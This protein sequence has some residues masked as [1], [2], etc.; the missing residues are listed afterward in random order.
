MKN[1]EKKVKIELFTE[2]TFISAGTFAE[3]YA[4]SREEISG[5]PNEKL[6]I[7]KWLRADAPQG[8]RD[9]FMNEIWALQRLQ[10]P[11]IPKFISEGELEGRP[12]IVMSRAPGRS[13]RK[14]LLDPVGERGTFGEKWVLRVIVALLSAVCSAQ[15]EGI[16][17][18]DIK[19][20]NVVCD[21]TAESV[22]LIDF[23]FCKGVSQPVDADSFFQVGAPRY[24]PPA[25]LRHPS[26]THPT[27]DVFAIGVLAYLLLTNTYP[28]SVSSDQDHGF[29]AD[30]M[31]NSI[32]PEVT[33]LNSTVSFE[34]AN[35]VSSLIIPD[36]Q[37]RPD[38]SISL[39]RAKEIIA[40]DNLRYPSHYT[41]KFPKV[42]RD[43]VHGDIR[44]TKN[45]V[46]LIDTSSFQRLRHI[47]QLG[48]ANLAYMGAQHTRLAHSTGAMHVADR[49]MLSITDSS[50]ISID[51]EERLL[52]RTYALVHDIT[53]M[54]YGHT[55]EDELGF[56]LRHD[57]N[58]ARTER[59]LQRDIEF[60]SVLQSSSYGKA[61]FAELNAGEPTAALALARDIVDGHA[62]ADVMDYIDRDSL[63][64]GVDHQVDTAIYRQFNILPIGDHSAG[65]VKHLV[66]K[67]YGSRGLRIDATFAIESLLI[68]R[69]ALFMKVYTHSAK[70]AAGAM[71]G[72]ALQDV[73]SHYG[74]EEVEVMIETM[75]DDELI[76]WLRDQSISESARHL[77]QGLL[78]RKLFVPI[79]AGEPVPIDD[80]N[81]NGY[82]DAQQWQKDLKLDT[83]AGRDNAERIIALNA[84]VRESDVIIYWT[85][86]APGLQKI[87]Y[88][89]QEAPGL[90]PLHSRSSLN[91][92]MVER[93]LS[94]WLIRI[95]VSPELP[96]DKKDN[97]RV[98]AEAF[99]GRPNL[100]RS[101]KQQREWF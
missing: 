65:P 36:D 49:I 1:V 44:L 25:K 61:V 55:L 67:V 38:A 40:S 31:E 75:G 68:Q 83:P 17:H 10:H 91:S 57:R 16:T 34:M 18:R 76:L 72:K 59:L 11:A 99:F 62:G 79:Y 94:I 64:C 97:V 63:Y 42:T 15:A 74:P 13:L 92:R 47:K 56:F 73:V 71:L 22:F 69:F 96:R 80:R 77:A 46:R 98:A 50:G 35:L 95:F 5:P 39:A 41:S 4:I 87:K 45:E 14:R 48:F 70:L 21:D 58:Q 43:P 26:V 82:A 32:P 89:F 88:Y 2:G 84:G 33:D 29:L 54:P 51:P 93:H 86:K 24:S 85:R 9:R 20:D 28:W 78:S 27:Q 7:M 30:L 100:V 66:T 23:G 8:G 3:A 90:T 19:D 101:R 53:H 81:L 37:R 6:A 12:Y 52:V 60:G